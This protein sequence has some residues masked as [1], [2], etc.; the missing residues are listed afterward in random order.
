VL[1]RDPIPFF[2]SLARDYGDVS[3]FSIGRQKIILLNEPELIRELLVVQQRSFHKSLVLQRTKVIFGSGLLISE[4]EFHL[5]QRRLA[6]PAFHRERI[7]RYADVMVSRALARSEMWRDGAVVDMHDEMMQLTLS[8][9]ARTLF[10]AEVESEADQIGAALSA[11]VEMFPMLMNP[12]FE[13]KLRLPFPSTLRFRAAMKRLDRTIYSIIHARRATNDDRGDLLSMLLLAQDVEGDGGTMTDKQLRDEAMTLFLAGHETTANALSWTFYLLAQHPEIAREAER[14]VDDVLGGRAATAADFPRLQYVE[15]LLAESMRLY[16][17][18]WAVSRLA[19]HDL[20]I[21]GWT[22]PKGAV[23]VASQAVMHRDPRFWPEP[24]R[25]DPARFAPDAKASRP[26]FSYFP[27]GGG[28]RICIGEGFA[29]ME[30]VLIL[31]TLMQRWRAELLPQTIVPQAS[32][33]LRPAGGI[34]MRLKERTP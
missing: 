6:Q 21:G 14:V 13:L 34:T 2:T 18:A 1:Q 30:G 20:E 3:Q 4:G 11:L 16:P 17:P 25:F 32:I 27:F 33:T 22:I 26:K 29:W 31:T 15:M 23:V 12:L 10:D 24:D 8:V 9:V 28:T 7:A 19:L 5:R